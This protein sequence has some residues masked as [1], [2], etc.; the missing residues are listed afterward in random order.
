[1]EERQTNPDSFYEK[2]EPE[3]VIV[4]C[5][6]KEVEEGNTESVVVMG[7]DSVFE[8]VKWCNACFNKKYEKY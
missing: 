8:V 6:G 1:M 4:D 2:E 3:T 7:A 5:C